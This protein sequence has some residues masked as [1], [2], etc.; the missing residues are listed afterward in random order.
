MLR[1]FFTIKSHPPI[2]ANSRT[3][4]LNDRENVLNDTTPRAVK[5]WATIRSITRKGSSI[6]SPVL[7]DHLISESIY[8]GNN[9]PSGLTS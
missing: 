1:I 4:R 9:F 3:L 2:L 5:T 7:K 6:F 8:A